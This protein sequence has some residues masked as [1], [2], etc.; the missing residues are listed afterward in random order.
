M[1][2]IAFVTGNAKKLAEV[3]HILGDQIK[4]KSRAI[5]RMPHVTQKRT[6]MLTRLTV[7][8]V[9]GTTRYIAETKC[10]AAAA[11]INGPCIVEDTSLSFK[12]M[13]TLPGP[14]IKWFLEQLGHEGL[15]KML[16]GFEDKSAE[17]LCTFAFTS[18][19]N[20]PIEIFEGVCPGR[21]VPARGSTDFGWDAVFESSELSKTFGEATREEKATVSHRF[22]A[23]TKL[24]IFLAEQR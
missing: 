5:D 21:I 22:R 8:E 6:K 10:A 2:T 7:P 20:Q 23:L 12:A 19:T 17:A 18:G 9:Q 13:G 1:D 4:L 14:Y 3:N 15:N 16:A 11:I 24:R